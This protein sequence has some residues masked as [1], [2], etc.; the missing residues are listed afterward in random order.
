[1]RFVTDAIQHAHCSFGAKRRMACRDEG[2]HGAEAELVGLVIGGLSVRL[3]R[4]HVVRRPGNNA[5]VSQARLGHVTRARLTQI[6]NMLNLAP[7][8]QEQ[9]LFLPPTERGHD[10]ITEKQLRPIASIPAW[11]MQR[12]ACRRFQSN[13]ASS[14]DCQSGVK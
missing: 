3:F 12:P 4:R 8:L 13:P 7:D 1:M 10:A 9:I 2:K 6:M 11:R 14:R 5:R